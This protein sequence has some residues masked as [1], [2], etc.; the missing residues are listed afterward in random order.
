[1]EILQ[2]VSKSTVIVFV[3]RICEIHLLGG[4]IISILY[5]GRGMVKPEELQSSK[6]KS[7]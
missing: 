5:V 1:M 2:Y 4:S 6:N 7:D 3:T